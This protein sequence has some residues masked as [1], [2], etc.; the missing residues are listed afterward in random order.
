MSGNLVLM[1]LFLAMPWFGL[2]CVSVVFPGH[3]RLFF[4]VFK[5]NCIGSASANSIKRSSDVFV[6]L[7]VHCIAVL[8]F[9]VWGV[10]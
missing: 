10:I 6:L 1:W 9:E 4:R 8:L 3:T 7:T 5:K 2:L